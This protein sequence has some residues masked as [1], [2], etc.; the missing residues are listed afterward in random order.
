MR[1][2][3]IGLEFAFIKFFEKSFFTQNFKGNQF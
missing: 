2:F 1:I 3:S